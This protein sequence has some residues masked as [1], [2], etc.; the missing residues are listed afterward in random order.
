MKIVASFPS[1]RKS[2]SDET[3]TV[4]LIRPAKIEY[5]KNVIAYLDEHI[6]FNYLRATN[7]DFGLSFSTDATYYVRVDLDLSLAKVL[8]TRAF[9]FDEE[10]INIILQIIQVN[11]DNN[12]FLTIPQ[13]RELKEN[14]N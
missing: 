12:I 1:S 10:V 9:P 3:V 5:Y 7:P 13:I 6:Y 14:I 2:F 11:L 4:K 8:Y